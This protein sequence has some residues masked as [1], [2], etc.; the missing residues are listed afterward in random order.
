MSSVK[1]KM[2][3]EIEEQEFKDHVAR[4]ENLGTSFI[5]T[6]IDKLGIELYHLEKSLGVMP[7]AGWT[8]LDRIKD[9]L[10]KLR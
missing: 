6:Q 10:A 3:E 1:K 8:T 7:R 2:L 4:L 9:I 5:A